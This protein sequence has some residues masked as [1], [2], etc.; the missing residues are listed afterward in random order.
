MQYDAFI[1]RVQEYAGLAT[2][3]EALELTAVVLA[4]LGERIHRAEQADLAAQLPRE[5]Q[6]LLTA[7]HPPEQIHSDVPRFS[8]EE[9]YNRVR[10]RAKIGYHDA[11]KQAKAVIAVL[12]EAVSAGAI[13]A[14]LA[15]LPDEYH[16]LFQTEAER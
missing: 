11:V 14:I 16:T 13:A 7:R 10:A 4:T 2:R 6:H 15:E 12:R 8:L 3:D 5:L 9:F 1:C